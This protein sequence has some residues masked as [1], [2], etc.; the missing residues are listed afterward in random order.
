MLRAR[1]AFIQRPKQRFFVLPGSDR[2]GPVT[3]SARVFDQ[4][5]MF[6]QE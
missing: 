5:T 1:V 6:E 4:K 2:E 3:R